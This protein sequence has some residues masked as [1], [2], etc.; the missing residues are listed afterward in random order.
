MSATR[1]SSTRSCS[2]KRASMGPLPPAKFSPRRPA[3]DQS[4][5]RG[6]PPAD[7]AFRALLSPSP[8]LGPPFRPSRRRS[9]LLA[10]VII[11][12]ARD[13]LPA[14]KTELL[15]RVL[16]PG[17]DYATPKLKSHKRVAARA[18]KSGSCVAC[19]EW[20]LNKNDRNH[21]NHTR[22][23][24]LNPEGV[25]QESPG[26]E[27]WVT[28]TRGPKPCKGGAACFALTG[29]IVIRSSFPRACALG[30]PA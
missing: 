17:T 24:G 30:S 2:K 28:G 26:R 7:A 5:P 18:P 10:A 11:D 12:H 9:A 15:S 3:P 1:P 20:R 29:L 6:S 21:L 25:R 4:Q 22:L 19:P 27:P 13:R 14:N 16:I 23:K 8:S